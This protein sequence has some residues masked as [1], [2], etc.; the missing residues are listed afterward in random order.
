MVAKGLINWLLKPLGWFYPTAK[1][2]YTWRLSHSLNQFEKGPILVLQ[3]GKV[4]SKSV[5]AGLEA[6]VSDRPIYHTHFLSRERTTHTEKTRRKFFRTER[7]RYLTRQWLN[8][9][10]LRTFEAHKEI[11]TWKLVTLTREPV[12]RNI[13]AF[14][15]NLYV[16]PRE[17]GG[18]YEI[19][20]DYYHIEPTIVSVNDTEKL[21][22]LFF[23]RARHDSPL[24]FFDR[25]I[26]D[27]FGIDVLG[28]GFPIEKGYEIYSTGP[29][30]LLVLKLEKLAENAAAAFREFLDID[31]FKLI[32]QNIG[33]DKVYAPLYDALKKYIVVDS[34]YADKLY[35]S[36][37]M[38]TFYSTE[39]I[40]AARCK[41]LRNAR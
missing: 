39:E 22:D 20:S 10:L 5:Q 27:I 30:E 28:S 6:R 18:E 2:L 40:E 41:W 8:R 16:V 9:F 17:V 31:D 12:G 37:Y 11:H 33:A 38:R 7:H 23:N 32:N 19:S 21:A 24:R 36:D 15:E 1:I 14:F 13:S 3:M 35:N 26:K 25:E 29:V 4:G 34:A